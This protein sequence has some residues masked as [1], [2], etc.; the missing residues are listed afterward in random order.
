MNLIKF[1]AIVI[2][3]EEPDKEC[4]TDKR[5]V[6]LPGSSLLFKN[7]DNDQI[8]LEFKK[9]YFTCQVCFTDKMGKD[10]MK[11]HKC[12]HVFCSECMKGYF[13]SQI[14]SGDIKKLICPFIKCET[15]ALQTQV[16]FFLQ[17]LIIFQNKYNNNSFYF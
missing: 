7:F 17:I 8:D 14:N 6:K 3:N 16:E 13:E 15:E 10:C 5:A 2:K 12:D 11:F 4:D 9:K 1:G